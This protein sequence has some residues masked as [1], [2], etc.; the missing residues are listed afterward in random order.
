MPVL[1]LISTYG[2]TLQN[3]E[4]EDEKDEEYVIDRMFNMKMTNDEVE[5]DFAEIFPTKVCDM[6]LVTSQ[7]NKLS[8][9]I[10]H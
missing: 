6:E 1:D 10:N 7:V 8:A 5:T 9:L 4:W 2:N 3:E